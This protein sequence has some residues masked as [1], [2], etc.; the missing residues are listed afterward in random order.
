M[1][2][3]HKVQPH[4]DLAARL[5]SVPRLLELHWDDAAG[6]LRD[7]GNHTQDVLLRWAGQQLPDGRVVRRELIRVVDGEPPRPQ[8]VPHFG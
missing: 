6:Q 3:Q 8:F 2:A 7:W 1:Q 4:A 5:G